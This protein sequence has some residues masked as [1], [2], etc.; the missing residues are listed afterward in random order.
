MDVRT[1]I[2][3]EDGLLV[4]VLTVSIYMFV[5]SFSFSYS[6]ALFP[7]YA[8]AATILS[9]CLLL[10]GKHTS[11]R[12]NEIRGAAVGVYSENSKMYADPDEDPVGAAE[13][14]D[15]DD[16]Q[17]VS[18]ELFTVL[19]TGGYVVLS[20]LIG[21]LWASPVF[22][23]VYTTWLG[24]KWRWRITLSLVGLGIAYLF[25]VILNAPLDE[26]VIT[27]FEVP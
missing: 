2:D 9:A 6:A 16:A 10:Y 12:L 17:P 24:L 20:F 3:S 26:G 11:G 5:G 1:D 13:P 14:E 15:G 19:S 18:D 23:V 7:R 22:V 21:M 27:L 25:M 4:T 8:A